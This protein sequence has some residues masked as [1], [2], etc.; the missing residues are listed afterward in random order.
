MSQTSDSSRTFRVLN[1]TDDVKS[2]LEFNKEKIKKSKYLYPRY[3]FIFDDFKYNIDD[4]ITTD[5]YLSFCNINNICY[6]KT[7][8]FYIGSQFKWRG[9]IHP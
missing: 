1:L 7:D 9:E 4:I 3:I 6:I 2:E 8:F 5:G